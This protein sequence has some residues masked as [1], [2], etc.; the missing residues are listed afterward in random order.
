MHSRN[1]FPRQKPGSAKYLLVSLEQ[2]K[3]A[4]LLKDKVYV[5]KFDY[6]MTYDLDSTLP[7]ISIH[8]HWDAP[9]YFEPAKGLPWGQRDDDALEGDGARGRLREEG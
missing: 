5:S 2:E 9:H 8:P 3:Y 1:D 4:P 6:V 7:M